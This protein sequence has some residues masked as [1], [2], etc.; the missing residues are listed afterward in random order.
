METTHPCP[1][2][3]MLNHMVMP[4]NIEA[5]PKRFLQP[6]CPGHPSARRLMFWA[7]G[8]LKASTSRVLAP[9]DPILELLWMSR[10]TDV[11]PLALSF[12]QF[13]SAEAWV[14]A[15]VRHRKRTGSALR[16]IWHVCCRHHS[17]ANNSE[18]R[19][20]HLNSGFCWEFD[21]NGPEFRVWNY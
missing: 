17:W 15:W 3:K 14:T 9:E 12:Q 7:F 13:P 19:R 10:D 1:D 11:W 16:R 6:P 4:L 8:A 20:G 5:R 2:Q 18:L 21:R